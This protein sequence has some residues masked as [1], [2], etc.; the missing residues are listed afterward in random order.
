M[1]LIFCFSKKF[2]MLFRRVVTFVLL[3][4]FCIQQFEYADDLNFFSYPGNVAKMQMDLYN[5]ELWCSSNDLYLNPEKYKV[6][7]FCR[8]QMKFPCI[9]TIHSSELELV[10]EI[11]DLWIWFDA[12]M[13]LKLHY[14]FIAAKAYKIL[15][16]IKR[17]CKDFVDRILLKSLYCFLIRYYLEY[18]S[19]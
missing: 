14:N 2:W 13:F 5:V 1:A 12:S 11:F 3:C 4:L 6:M 9:Y 15:S 7:V 18:L 16:F 8:S 19:Q 10:R 17:N